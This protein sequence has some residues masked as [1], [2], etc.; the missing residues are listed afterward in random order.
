MMG[1]AGVERARGARTMAVEG[2]AEGAAMGRAVAESAEQGG[3]RSWVPQAVPQ[4]AGGQQMS[5]EG[6]AGVSG[7]R[8]TEMRGTAARG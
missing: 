1:R 5:T 3:R 4:A 7:R 6:R 2:L 8:Q